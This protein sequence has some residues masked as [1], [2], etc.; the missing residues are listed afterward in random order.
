ME[1]R[2]GSSQQAFAQGF[3]CADCSLTMTVPSP[4]LFSFNTAF[5]ACPLCRGFGKVIDLDLHRVVP[6]ER[7][8]I[9]EGAIKPF[10]TR[11]GRRLQRKCVRFCGE[12]GIPVDVP[13]AGLSAA[14]RRLVFDG[15][16]GYPGVRG[17][18]RRLEKKKYKMHVRVFL[19]RYRAY[20][21]CPD[22][23]GSRL[24]PEALR[25]RVAGKTLP[26]LWDEPIRSLRRFFAGIEREPLEKPTRLVVEEISSRL[27]YLDAVGLDYLTLG[28]Q[29]RTLSGAKC[30]V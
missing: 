3:R 11:K 5:G 28:R 10:S 24:R 12:A 13:F 19:A 26:Q 4:G 16:G 18:F 27:R 25:F 6:D 29:S 22:C 1:V 17:F 21:P 7:L 20:E 14:Q 2:W 9:R 30:S 23:G 15:G 8:S